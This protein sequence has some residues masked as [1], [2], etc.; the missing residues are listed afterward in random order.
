[1]PYDSLTIR[2]LFAHYSLTKSFTV[3][4]IIR[5]TESQIIF[6]EFMFRLTKK[7]KRLQLSTMT[8]QTISAQIKEWLLLFADR[9]TEYQDYLTAL[10][11]TIGDGDHGVNMQR[12]VTILSQRLL[13]IDLD[14][15]YRDPDALLRIIGITMI[16][17]IGGAAGPLYAAFFLNAADAAKSF[18]GQRP[19]APENVYAS[20]LV[21]YQL[22]TLFAQGLKGIQQRGM[23]KGGEKTMVDT[24]LPVMHSLKE[25]R[26]NRADIQQAMRSARAAALEGM[27]QTIPLKA[28]KG[29]AS[30]LGIRSIGHQDPGA[31]SIYL[32]IETATEVFGHIERQPISLETD[33]ERAA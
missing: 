30:Y 26:A 20:S 9:I 13:E 11:E 24:L 7:T 10:D 32:L 15:M 8:N 23:V 33:N 4:F 17:H 2:S 21:L 27:Q 3:S 29:R 6:V 18:R 1:M 31:T 25:S 28:T 16:N 22:T 12:T 5:S 14:T 19:K